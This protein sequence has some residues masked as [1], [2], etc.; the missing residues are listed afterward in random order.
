LV[1]STGITRKVDSLGRVVL[2]AEVRRHFGIREGDLVEISVDE[3]HIVLGKA[4][5]R[6]VFCRATDDLET[7]AGKLVCASCITALARGRHGPG[8]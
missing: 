8:G 2:P 4:E 7:F 3:D 5:H 1:R 6:C